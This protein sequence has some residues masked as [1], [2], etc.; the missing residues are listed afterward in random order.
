MKETPTCILIVNPRSGTHDKAKIVALALEKLTA[1]GWNAKAVY[2]ERAGHATEIAAQAAAN[3]ADAVVAVGGDGTV[4]ETARALTGTDTI[5]GIIPVGSGNGLAR[6]LRV[7]MS[8]AKAIDVIA[9]GEV[10]ECDYCTVNGRP[11][12]CTFGMGYDAAVSAHFAA[13]PDSR[14]FINYLRSSVE[15]FMHYRPDTYEIIAD[16]ETLT[17]SAFT[18]ACCNAAQYGNNAF[19]APQASVTDGLMDVTIMHFGPWYKRMLCGLD[20]MIGTIHDGAR[21]HTLRTHNLTIKRAHEGPIHLD[22]DPLDGMGT[23]LRVECRHR[24]LKVFSP[25]EM[26]VTPILTTLHI[27]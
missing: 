21:I 8:P 16:D 15:V 23:E 22:G 24:G 9:R 7:P 11:F 4:N 18:I 10:V 27:K 20:L 12:F 1:V 2:T 17:D 14:G 6:H 5:L 19:I 26:H 3:G 25:G 13:R